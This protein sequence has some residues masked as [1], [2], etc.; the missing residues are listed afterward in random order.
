M[1]KKIVLLTISLHKGGAENQLVKLAIYLKEKG[2]NV[3][4]FGFLAVN[5]FNNVLQI[6]QITFKPFYLNKGI[7]FINLFRE[8]KNNNTDVLIS[9]MFAANIV[10]RFIK[11]FLNSMLLI[12]S[13]RAGNIAKKYEFIY[14]I[15]SR[16]D[17]V[18]TF[19]SEE[20]LINFTK[21][22]LTNIETSHFVKNGITIPVNFKTNGLNEIFT[23]ISIAHFRPEKDYKTLFN[24]ISIIKNRGI[25]IKLLVLGEYNEASSPINYL[26]ELNIEEEVELFGFVADTS[27]FLLK[28]DALILS[29]FC[30]GTPN[31]ILE[32]MSYRLPIIA[33]NVPGCS[34]LVKK[35]NCGFTAKLEDANDLSLKMIKL[36]CLSDIDLTKLAENGFKYVAENYDEKKVF[37]QWEELINSY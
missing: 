8:V 14:R 17:D 22:N 2:Y 30:E 27:R 16:I 31:A 23:F 33:S 10:A 5:D 1:K 34:E 9:F 19:N 32:G 12:T 28:S 15:T 6:H 26:K 13:V 29:S 11:V 37:Y 36:M 20:A 4:I 3:V 21:K 35:A 18:S 25:K 7:G 24:A